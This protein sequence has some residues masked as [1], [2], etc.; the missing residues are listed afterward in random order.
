MIAVQFE[1][2]GDP[3]VLHLSERERPEPG[4]RSVMIHVRAAGISPVDL[5]LRAG[6]TPIADSLPL[7]HVPGIDAA[8]VVV[9]VGAGVTDVKPGDD[10]F[11]IVDLAKLGGAT[12][13]FAV[14]TTWALRPQAFPWDQAAA[15][16]TSV[17]TATRAL[18]L[19]GVAPGS[20]LLIEGAAGGVGAVAAQLAVA[21]GT[22]VIGTARAETIEVVAALD[23]VVPVRAGEFL[24]HDLRVL[25]IGRVDRAL[26]A[27]G[28]GILREL[29]SL[30]GSPNRVV[31]IADF[32]AAEHG[33]RLTRGALAGEADGQHGLAVAANHSIRGQF[34]VPIRGT[35][36]YSRAVEAH[37]VAE[38]RPRWGKVVLVNE[39]F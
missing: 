2:P 25:G 37:R 26:D 34:R 31:T 8:G 23:G 24:E 1:R 13:E 10:I 22:R 38:Q 21:R 4:P 11:G 36:P 33:I 39:A 14:L 6:T 28:A 35:F 15:A 29:V 5:G 32:S 27:S 16:G 17:E 9:A 3:S 30:T 19:L 20:T 18:D 12:A 7:P